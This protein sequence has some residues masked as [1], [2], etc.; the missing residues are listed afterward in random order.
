[1]ASTIAFGSGSPAATASSNQRANCFIGEASSISGVSVVSISDDLY[2]R[3]D[4][5]GQNRG[6]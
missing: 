6:G 5:R 2:T 3:P 1:V 4:Y